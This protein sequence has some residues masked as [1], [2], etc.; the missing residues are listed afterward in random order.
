MTV[1]LDMV[2]DPL[3]PQII[4]ALTERSQIM[5]FEAIARGDQI[6]CKIK[7]LLKV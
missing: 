3:Q 4:Y 5:I 1:I 6:D 2:V 7:G